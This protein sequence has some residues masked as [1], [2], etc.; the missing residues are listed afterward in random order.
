LIASAFTCSLIIGIGEAR[1]IAQRRARER[2]ELMRVTLGSIGD[3]VITTDIESRITYLNA[4]AELLTGWRQAN[5]LHQPLDNV[6]RI[7]DE[8]TLENPGARALREDATVGLANDA[9]L[10]GKDGTERP[11]DSAA[12]PI[13]DE[14]GKVSGCVLIFR[15][16][17]ERRRLQKDAASRMRG[18]RLLASIVESSDD[19]II[20]KSLDGIIE[21]WNAAAKRVFGYAAKD[22]V[23]RHIT[24][25]IPPDRIAEEDKIIAGIKAGQR[26][27]HFETER[28]RSD[29]R[30]ILVSLTISPVKDDAATS[31]AHRR[32]SAT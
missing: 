16:I 32:S 30:R 4:V 9:V 15:D 3:A 29:G 24:L 18:A 21:S 11:I 25:V 13:K 6:F 26:V 23:G 27:D 22:A 1:R 10:I 17:S 31:S 19:A 20:S 5:A 7:I 14:R 28:V 12:A 8:Q 2:G